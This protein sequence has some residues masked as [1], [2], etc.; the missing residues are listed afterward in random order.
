LSTA[1]AITA[2]RAPSSLQ[3]IGGDAWQGVEGQV[4]HLAGGDFQQFQLVRHGAGVA[5]ARAFVVGFL[6]TGFGH[7][8]RHL[9]HAALVGILGA[10]DYQQVTPAW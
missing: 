9:A 2:T 5:H 3:R 1:C 7:V 8:A 4:G 10:G 6:V